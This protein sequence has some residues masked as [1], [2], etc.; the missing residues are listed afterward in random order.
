MV[1]DP[2]YA[3]RHGSL[4]GLFGLLTTLQIITAL[5]SSTLLILLGSPE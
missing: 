3:K 2:T 1:D 5:R 4:L